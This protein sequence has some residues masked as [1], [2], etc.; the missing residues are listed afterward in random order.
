M[1][2]GKTGHSLSICPRR[3]KGRPGPPVNSGVLAGQIQNPSGAQPHLQISATIYFQLQ[4][5]PL[6]ALIYSGAEE[7]FIDERAADQADIPSEPLESPPRNALA[8]D[9]R[10]LARV[11]HRTVPVTLVLSDDILIYS[12]TL[13]DHQLHVRQVLQRLLEN[14]LFVK[15]EKCEFHASQVSF[16]GFILKEGRVQADPEKIKAVAEWPN[17]K[18]LQ[19]FLGFANFYWRF[20]RN[21]WRWMLLM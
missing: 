6:Q 1:Y 18:L 20:I 13:T 19:R 17:W 7:N 5:L 11:T 3:P 8:V 10:K 21:W 14:R 4:R 9:G 16:L 15:K 12:K 2:R